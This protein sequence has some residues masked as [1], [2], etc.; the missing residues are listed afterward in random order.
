MP[1]I[2]NPP[3]SLATFTVASVQR[4]FDDLPVAVATSATPA[5]AASALQAVT[6]TVTPNTIAEEVAF[7]LTVTVDS[8]S[9]TRQFKFV[10][11]NDEP[12]LTGP[13][14]VTIQDD[15]VQDSLFPG[16]G[17]VD[18]DIGATVGVAI[19]QACDDALNELE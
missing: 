15:V 12:A 4:S 16:F 11:K 17:I 9:V 13:A 6:V 10:P 5:A 7:N 1:P 18:G 8:V 19:T 2:T 14:T 3:S